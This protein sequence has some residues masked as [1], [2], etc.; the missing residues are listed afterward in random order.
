MIRAIILAAGRG[1]RMGQLG[2]DSP[3][4]LTEIEGQ[5]LLLRQVAALRR[6]GVDQIGVVRGYLAERIN[7]PGLSYFANKR[8]AETNMVMSLASAATWLRSGPV[9]VSYADIFYRSD[10]VRGL[11]AASGQLVIS[12]DRAWRGLWTRRF[13]DPLADAETFRIDASGKLLEIGGKTTR[14]EEIEGQYMGL[15]KFT[16]PAWNAVEGLLRAM[17]E[18]I[19]DRLDMTGLLRRLLAG[20]EISINTVGTEGHWGEIDQPDDLAL[21]HK[22]V[23]DGQLVL[24]DVHS[25]GEVAE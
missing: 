12:Y 8:W 11:V 17:D 2:G 5:P 24:E 22:M 6:G 20:N 16:P 4:C 18:P 23:R 19:R 9:I 1:S 15:L 21:Y 25:E 14:I 13:S 3:K 7:F 10:V